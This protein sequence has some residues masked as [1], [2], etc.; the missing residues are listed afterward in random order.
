MQNVILFALLGLGAGALIASIALGVVLIYRGSGVINVAVGAIAMTGAYFFWSF[1]TGYFGFTLSSAPAYVLT[2]VCMAVLGLVIELTIFRPLRNTAPLAKLAASLGLLLILQAG[3]IVVFGDEPKSAPYLSNRLSAETVTIFDRV[4][5]ID[6]FVLA[7]IV[8][9]VAAAL[10]ALYRWTPFGLSTRAA[11]ENE[12][13]AM[14]AG[15]SPSRLAVLNTMLACVVAGGLGVL[16]APLITL[17]ALTLALLVVPALGAALLAGFTSFFIA[18]FAGL[19]MGAI[20]WLIVYWSSQSWFPTDEGGAPLRGVYE[21]FV[22][23]VIVLALFLRGASLPGRGELVEKRL[24]AVPVPERLVRWSVIGAAVCAAC[25]VVFPYLWRQALINS[26]L[27]IIIC[28]SLVVIIGF[29]GQ[30]SVVQLALAGVAGFTMS[31]LTTDVGGIWAEF[32][33]SLLI[34]ACTATIVGLVVGFSALRVRGV[35]LAVVT[36]AAAVALEQFGFLNSRW[37]G[38]P[39][40]SPVEQPT[41]GGINLAPDA[42]FR[43]LDDKLPSPVFGFLV[44]AFTILM[45]LLVANVRRS[46]LGQRMLAVRSN[47]R[48]AAAAGINVR[49]TKLAGFAIAS[50]VAGMAGAL[51]A[52]NFGSVSASRFGALA[53][54]GLIAFTYF[55]GITMVSGAILAGVGAAEALFPTAFREW[56][57][58]SGT[59]ALLVGGFALIITLII[60]PEGI[61]GT[62]WKKQQ[63]KK[64]RRA[65][66]AA[67]EGRARL[68]PAPRAPREAVQPR[69]ERKK[70]GP[71]VLQATG[72]SV[73]F[74]GLR[75]LDDVDLAVAEGQLVGL[76][77]PNGAGKTTFIDAISG[78]VPYRGKVELDGKGLDRLQAHRRAERG[79]ARTWQSI[80]LFDDLSVRENLAVASYHPSTFATVKET[81]SRPVTSTKAAEEALELLGLAQMANAMPDELTQGQ[82]KLVGI[83]RALAAEP[84]LLC[85]DEPAAGLDAREGE[86]LGRRLREVVDAGTPILLVDHDMGLV[87]GISDYV[88]VLEFGRVIAQGAPDAVRR[89]PQVIEAYLGAAAAELEAAAEF[90]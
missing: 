77:G 29:V 28:L 37:G 2:L 54:L 84:R 12:V 13:S 56:F 63:Q 71:I 65:A 76:I 20:Q 10:A 53:A 34:G 7:G 75:A 23:L 30:I 15:L 51:Y 49:N 45:A 22:F 26:L 85:L 73:S 80:E 55:G 79:L 69:R 87:L 21:L 14:L 31:H 68:E 1:K 4:V 39:R 35:S 42:G 41:L 81:L 3:A 90:R 19:A 6:R 88:V 52:Y 61:A 40:G 58:L 17:D 47:E 59:W 9:V 44:L 27:G 8:I 5:P 18:C 89:D 43:G 57:H 11:S 78:F 66:E 70:P 46:S 32:P 38:G 25:L 16:V 33:I 60:N 64:K 36:L 74:G 72:I 50:F 86:E 83:G 48:S 67:A 24:P 62:G 82:R